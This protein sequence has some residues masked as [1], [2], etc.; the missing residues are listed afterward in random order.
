VQKRLPLDPASQ[1]RRIVTW[2]FSLC[3]G[4]IH[5]LQYSHR[6][7][8]FLPRLLAIILM[9]HMNRMSNL[10]SLLFG[11]RHKQDRLSRPFTHSN[12]TYKVCLDCGRHV[13]YD[14]VLFRPLTRSEI[15]R[16]HQ[17]E[18]VANPATDST[19]VA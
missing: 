8:A 18:L 2:V 4:Y 13:P 15:K 1:M 5:R 16:L 17:E 9:R 11:C 3:T 7:A 10:L 6:P 19:A 14:A 12:Q